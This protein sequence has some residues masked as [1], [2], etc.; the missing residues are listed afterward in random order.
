M[1]PHESLRVLLPVWWP[2]SR[3]GYHAGEEQEKGIAAVLQVMLSHREETYFLGITRGPG[4]DEGLTKKYL[5][6]GTA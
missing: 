6:P 4:A 2:M 5:G 3:R 1:M